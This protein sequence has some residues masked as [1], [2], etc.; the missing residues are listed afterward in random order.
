[1]NDERIDRRSFLQGAAASMVVLFREEELRAAALRQD[2]LPA[3]P[4]VR[5]GVIGAG[6]W[7]RE[8][9]TALSRLPSTR[10]LAVC[11]TY[12]PYLKKALELA[13]EASAESDYRKLLDSAAIEAVVIATPTHQHREIALAALDAGKHVYCEAPLAARMEDAQAIVA[14]ALHAPQRVFQTGLQGRSNAL[15]RH[16][17]QFVKTGVLGSGVQVSAQWNKKQSWRRV[18]PDPER[19]RQVNWRLEEGVSLGLA[20]EIGIHQ[21]DLTGWYLK[22][23]PLA[24]I[25]FGS[26]LQWRDGRK[27]P[28]TIQCVFEYP[29]DVRAIFSSTLA[30]S[31]GGAYA[32]FQGSNSSLMMRETRGWMVKEADSPLL[33]WE[34]YARKETINDETGICMVADAT[35]LLDAGKEP[36]KEGSLGPAQTPLCSAFE[37]FTRS[38]REGFRP[39][40]GAREGYQAAVVAIKANEAVLSGSRIS[41]EPDWFDTTQ[42]RRRQT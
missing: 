17:G 5:I 10:V 39:A 4:P 38:I 35:K 30:S 42:L 41:Y 12:P 23:L 25:G 36:G 40:C 24:V 37:D 21:F 16:V 29:N 28:D 20:G 14:A 15:Y 6:A 13:P 19:E 7:G 26:I 34:V 33:G 18:A 22:S 32:L 11:E 2:P 9:L 27:V 31:F 8:I 3:W 1:M